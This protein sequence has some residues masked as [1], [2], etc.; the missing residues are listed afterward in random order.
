M[1]TRLTAENGAK[2]LLLGKFKLE[3]TTECPECRELEEPLEGCEACDGGGNTA[4]AHDPVGSNQIHLQRG[5]EGPGEK[6]TPL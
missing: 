2:A 3:V 5:R 1:P 6:P 4:A